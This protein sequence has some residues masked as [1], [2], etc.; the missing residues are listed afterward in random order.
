MKKINL[1][2]LVLLLYLPA[3]SQI[4]IDQ[5]DMPKEGDTLRMSFTTNILF[6]YTKTGLDTTWD[7]SSLTKMGQ[8]IDTFVNIQNVPPI[9]LFIFTPNLVST[10][11][12]PGSLPIPI[13]DIPISNFFNFYKNSAASYSY[14]G[15]AFQLSGFP[16]MMKYN[17]P[18]VWYS[19]PC[20]FGSTWNSESMSSA[21]LPGLG[22]YSTQRNRTS[23]VDGWGNLITPLGTFPTIRIKSQWVEHDS[24]YLDTLGMGFPFDRNV[25][26][27]KWLGKNQGEPLL[28]IMVEGLTGTVTATYRDVINHTGINEIHK[29]WIRISPNPSTSSFVICLKK[30][31][32]A[33]ELEIFS[34]EGKMVHS[35]L[36]EFHNGKS[37]II[38]SKDLPSGTYFLQI[39]NETSVYTGIILIKK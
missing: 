22:Y 7:F 37:N 1:F 38:N 21:S 9:Y 29:E 19:F 6:D 27:Y 17:S 39:K 8:Q 36:T 3:F 10:L 12:S 30:Q 34:T 35:E 18:D 14:P 31:I 2:T 26:E 23:Q 16:I 4:T 24:I 25:T 5:N 33:A 13:P 11:A 32:N 28:Q 15:F 20:T